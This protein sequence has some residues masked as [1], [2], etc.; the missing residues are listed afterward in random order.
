MFRA[1]ETIRERLAY[2][3]GVK[4]DALEIRDGIASG[5][6]KTASVTDLLAGSAIEEIGRIKPGKT[7]Q[8]YAQGSYGAFFA[9]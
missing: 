4:P 7:S 1:C 2:Q 6:G 8:D 5:D 9:E 3:L